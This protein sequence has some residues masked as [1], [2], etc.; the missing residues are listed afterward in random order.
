MNG[1]DRVEE[2]I[3]KDLDVR[4]SDG[5]YD[6]MRDVVL[7][8]HGRSREAKSA[9]ALIRTRSILMKNP[10]AKLAIT[11]A[12]V[13]AVLVGIGLFRQS[14]SGVV[15]AEVAQKVEASPGVTWRLR[16]TGENDPND[17]WPKG[18]TLLQRSASLT[19]TDHYRDGKA[20]RTIYYDVDTKTKVLVAHDAKKY[21]KEAMSDE[22]V[23]RVR[24]DKERWSNPGDLVNLAL[25]LEHHELGQ[26]T[27]NGVLCE[28]IEATIPN[29]I[30]GR[31]W[32]AAETGYPVLVEVEATDDGGVHRTSTL[33]QFRWNVDLSAEDVEPEIP[34]DYEP[35]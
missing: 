31:L 11:A 3:R 32:V 13:A 34:A 20:Y 6:R 26:K 4:A 18:Y 16:K 12:V 28:G 25:S 27:I 29:G 10:I 23:Q 5:T 9:N 35:L 22:Q 21:I 30:S 33:D 14:G 7:D 15:W 2:S 17:D 24:A 1:N 8:A 19:R